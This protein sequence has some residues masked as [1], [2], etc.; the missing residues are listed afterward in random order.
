MEVWQDQGLKQHALIGG[1]WNV[2]RAQ[3]IAPLLQGEGGAVNLCG[4]RAATQ[5]VSGA[6]GSARN[7]TT[8]ACA[9]GDWGET[10]CPTPGMLMMVALDS[11]AAACFAPASDVSVS[12]LPEM[13]SVGS[14]TTFEL[15]QALH[16]HRTT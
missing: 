13:R 16:E 7:D 11:F 2:A 5:D 12:K 15:A 3:A 10:A 6:L 8:T 1:V 14:M 9:Q 4:A